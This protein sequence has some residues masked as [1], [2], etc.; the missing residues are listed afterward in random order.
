MKEFAHGA[1]VRR[2]GGTDGRDGAVPED[3]DRR[4]V[5][6]CGGWGDDTH[7]YD[8]TP[9]VRARMQAPK[10]MAASVLVEL[11]MAFF[12]SAGVRHASDSGTSTRV[13]PLVTRATAMPGLVHPTLP[14][15]LTLK[16][17]RKRRRGISDSAA[18]KL[19]PRPRA[20]ERI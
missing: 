9:A 12:L 16:V 14:Q 2:V 4:R 7:R 3:Q 20:S 1:A 8:L 6:G 18:E 19:P 15:G 13:E 5:D 11:I 10:A 17:D